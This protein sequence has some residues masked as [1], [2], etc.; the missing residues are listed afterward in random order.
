MDYESLKSLTIDFVFWVTALGVLFTVCKYATIIFN[1]LCKI[2]K[3]TAK[4]FNCLYYNI[5]KLSPF[6]WKHN[7][8]LLKESHVA[9]ENKL[10]S[11]QEDNKRIQDELFNLKEEN[12][13]LKDMLNFKQELYFDKGVFWKNDGTG[14]FCPTCFQGPQKIQAYLK[15]NNP[16][17]IESWVCTACHKPHISPDGHKRLLIADRKAKIRSFGIMT[18]SNPTWI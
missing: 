4:L 17:E 5:Q 14:P 3:T 15:N 6:V 16:A 11:T 18:N 2:L 10:L 8:T 7:Y 12:K 13:K 1:F 9:T